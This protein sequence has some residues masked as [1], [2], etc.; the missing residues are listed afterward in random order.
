M[1]REEKVTLVEKLKDILDSNT[2]VVLSHYQGLNMQQMTS[3][4]QKMHDS[5]IKC[6][7]IKNTLVKLAIKGTD[8]SALES[9]LKGPTII[10]ASTDP[11]AVAKILSEFSKDND[12]LKL[13]SAIVD[14]KILDVSEITLLS[15]MPSLDELRAKIVGLLNAPATS[16]ATVLN[17]PAT[18]VA[19]VTSLYAQKEQ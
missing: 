19:R 10:S 6:M 12:K 2:A 1:L 3:L 11:V 7:I 9:H 14:N 5:G 17:A 16:L 18:Q 4:R 15:K 8:F 13:I